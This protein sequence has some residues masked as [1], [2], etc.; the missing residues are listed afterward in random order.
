MGEKRERNGR[1]EE[2]RRVRREGREKERRGKGWEGREASREG[3]SRREG[4]SSGRVR[5][6]PPSS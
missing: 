1:G 3:G 4:K 6:R 2:G 5:R